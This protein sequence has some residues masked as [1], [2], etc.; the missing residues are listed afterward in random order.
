[1][2]QC[3]SCREV[4]VFFFRVICL[5]P[6]DVHLSRCVTGGPVELVGRATQLLRHAPAL[7]RTAL[8]FPLLNDLF[9]LGQVSAGEAPMT[10]R[11]V[12]WGWPFFRLRYRL[13]LEERRWVCWLVGRATHSLN[14]STIRSSSPSVWRA[15]L[16]V[17]F[18]FLGAAFGGRAR[19]SWVPFP[20][21]R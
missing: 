14:G 4:S 8:I 3:L 16:G 5:I 21:I 9:R 19:K 20:E 11:T 7:P 6:L 2:T 12:H 10:K 18:I 15:A 17:T 1:M 13:H